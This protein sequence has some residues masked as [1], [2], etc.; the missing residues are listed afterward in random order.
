MYTHNIVFFLSPP[1]HRA[2]GWAQI[3]KRITA[4]R[5]G[6]QNYQ[7]IREW[8]LRWWIFDE[9]RAFKW[10]RLWKLSVQNKCERYVPQKWNKKWKSSRI[11]QWKPYT[12]KST[13]IWKQLHIFRINSHIKLKTTI[14]R[15]ISCGMLCG[16]KKNIILWR[17]KNCVRFKN[18]Q[19]KIIVYS[20][21]NFYSGVC[22]WNHPLLEMKKIYNHFIPALWKNYTEKHT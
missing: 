13:Y 8:I 10:K 12:S 2:N 11:Y 18:G 17:I 1:T 4:E 19:K 9:L 7:L 15:L 5:D 16:R 3:K 6:N 21:H 20:P 14:K 22:V